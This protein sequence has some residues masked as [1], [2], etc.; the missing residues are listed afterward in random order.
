MKF[1][2]VRHFNLQ[3]YGATELYK[4][5][6]FILMKAVDKIAVSFIFKN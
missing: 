3:L 4:W 1:D 2:T 6:S 5:K